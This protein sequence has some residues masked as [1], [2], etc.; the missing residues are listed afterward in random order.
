MNKTKRGQRRLK[1]YKRY[2]LW[3]KMFFYL[4]IIT[5][6]VALPLCVV[7]C[8]IF[9]GYEFLCV[10]IFANF[11][12]F[13]F[14]TL[15]CEWL[16]LPAPEIDFIHYKIEPASWSEFTKAVTSE[17][18][19]NERFKV[20]NKRKIL[21]FSLKLYRFTIFSKSSYLIMHNHM[22]DQGKLKRLQ[23]EIIQINERKSKELDLF[24]EENNTLIDRGVV[25]CFFNARG[26][27][28]IV[29]YFQNT[30]PQPLET[31]Y[32]QMM[33]DYV[34]NK[35]HIVKSEGCDQTAIEAFFM[36][37]SKAS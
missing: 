13:N 11:L 6:F 28:L 16:A 9:D 37:A 30:K 29:P 20:Y 7:G 25:R 12:L 26:G 21:P 10:M 34:L 22:Q 33:L 1:L 17:N 8:Y 3:D 27:D 19:S 32:Y 4:I 14:G 18:L 15:L 23:L 2:L 31:M 36:F 24:F 5:L 35:V